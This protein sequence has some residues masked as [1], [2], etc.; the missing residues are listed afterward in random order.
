MQRCCIVGVKHKGTP[1]GEV[2]KI[3]NIRAYF[4]IPETG[5]TQNAVLIMTDILGM[6]SPNVQLIADQ[7]AANGYLAVIPDVFNGNEVPFPAPASFDLQEYIKSKMPRVPAVDP[8]FETVIKHLRGELGVKR[9]GG[10]G[11]C[12][13]GKYVCRWLKEGGLD[14]GFT[15]H[16]SFVDADEV[17]GIQGPLS[18]AAAE[19]DTIFPAEKRRETEDIL[20]NLTVPYQITLYSD[21]EHGFAVRGDMSDSKAKFAKELAFLQAL[22]WFDEYVKKEHV[23][24]SHL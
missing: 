24:T 8:M 21:V 9:L 15:G 13:G 10:V 7:F 6:D 19:T 1:R 4:S 18:I 16:P 22:Y 17:R 2:R 5:G 3:E 14:A 11:Y 23:N 12:F 20:K